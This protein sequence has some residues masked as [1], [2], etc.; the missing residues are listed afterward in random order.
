MSA[1]ASVR[2]SDSSSSLPPASSSLSEFVGGVEV[3]LD[4]PLVAAGD[5]DHVADAG[6]VGLLDRVLDQGLV[7]DRQHLLGLRLRG[8]QEPGAQAGDRED[9]FVNMCELVHR[10]PVGL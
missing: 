10:P 5:E 3:V 2:T 7:H 9:R 4:R 8:G 6:L 1:G